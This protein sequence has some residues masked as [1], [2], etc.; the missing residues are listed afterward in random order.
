MRRRLF[1]VCSALSLLLLLAVCVLWVR[2]YSRHGW[3]NLTTFSPLYWVS[4]DGGDLRFCRKDNGAGGNHYSSSGV[5]GIRYIDAT[6]QGA[7]IRN[8]VIPFWSVALVT[9][10]L[11]AC[12]PLSL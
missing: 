11:P 7:R 12:W 5:L 9:S 6:S 10:V 1:T 3:I 2:S 4:W 8:V